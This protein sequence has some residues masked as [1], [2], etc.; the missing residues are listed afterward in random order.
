[1]SEYTI[2]GSRGTEYKVVIK[3]IR[4]SCTC[5]AGRF[6]TLCKHVRQAAKEHGETEFNQVVARFDLAEDHYKSIKKESELFFEAWR[7]DPNP[8]NLR[9][10]ENSCEYY[11]KA[12]VIYEKLKAEFNAS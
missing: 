1:M 9:H 4:Y 10:L 8:E 2:V 5:M 12:A 7:D 3:G 11:R 6:G